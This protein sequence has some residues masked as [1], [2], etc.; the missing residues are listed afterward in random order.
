MRKVALLP[1]ASVLLLAGTVTGVLTNSIPPSFA[2]VKLGEA[3]PDFA[4]PDSDGKTVKLSDFKGQKVLVVYFYPKD[5]TSVCTK[6]SCTFRDRYEALKSA[7][8]EVIGISSDTSESHKKFAEHH[9]L[10]FILLADEGGKVRKEW[11]VKGLLG[12][13]GRTT[14]V[15]DKEGIIRLVF[16]DKLNAKKHVDEAVAEVNKL[17]GK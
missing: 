14:F 17:T 16:S 5:E 13:P 12:V 3:A 2:E 6:E 10:P 1:L 7:G 4:L 8:A 15:V 9:K 11:G